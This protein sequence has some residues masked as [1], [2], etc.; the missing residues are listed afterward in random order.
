[1]EI[2]NRFR[3]GKAVSK[4]SINASG[5]FNR[6]IYEEYLVSRSLPPMKEMIESINVEVPAHR[7]GSP[8][9]WV[10]HIMAR[11][12]RVLQLPVI[13]LPLVISHSEDSHRKPHSTRD[14]SVRS[15]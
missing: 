11:V 7:C 3:S 10:L 15:I 2:G 14:K 8:L 9:R 5:R 12:P 1:M 4:Y 6:C 13:A